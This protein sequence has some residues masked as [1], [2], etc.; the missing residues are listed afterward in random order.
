[1]EFLKKYIVYVVVAIVLIISLFKI[2]GGGEINKQIDSSKVN[3]YFFYGNGCPHCA[4]EEVF[5][6]D[7]EKK[8][9]KIEIHRYETWYNTENAALLDKIRNKIGFKTGVPALII[10]SEAIVGYSNYEI[11]GKK[12]EGIVNKYVVEGCN[13]L[14]APY[15]VENGENIPADKAPTCEH[16]C[17]AKGQECEHDCACSA[18]MVNE[19]TGSTDTLNVPFFGE[20]N[21]KNL[22]MPAFTVLI[23]A[24]DGFNPCAMW[25]LL[26][27]LNLLIGIQNKRRM[28]IL[29]LA[30]I[31]SSAL[32]YYFFVFTWLQLFLFVGMIIWVRLAIG[33]LAV[34]SGTYHLKEYFENK[35]ASCKVTDNEKR[36]KMFGNL[37]EIV[38]R[39]S[40]VF[41]LI[42]IVLLAAAV[43]M[44]ELLC[45]AGFPQT[46]TQV[47]ALKHLPWW[48]NQ[49]YLLLYIVIFMLDDL[50]IFFL[51][52]KTMQLKGISS[53][54]SRWSGLV[55]G[56]MIL[57]IGLLLIFKPEWI[58]FG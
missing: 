16:G 28:W 6:D 33:I 12:I 53:R 10:G 17:E 23:A 9:D 34:G 35:D 25:V 8:Y 19:K 58:M 54:Y 1:M 44:V 41:A 27:L 32:V 14:V 31:F 39:K 36:Q 18:D 47:L 43:N 5:L 11:T 49:L 26:F 20:I 22:T 46:F 24:A 37:R 42:G 51:A 21:I 13:D 40:L 7:L 2:F 38:K 55:G 48:Q 52:M 4:K 57:L 56:I 3:L 30:F 45:S 50:F 15:F 29:G